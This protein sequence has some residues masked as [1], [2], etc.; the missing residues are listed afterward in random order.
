MKIRIVHCC[1]KSVS[2][3]S[4]QFTDLISQCAWIKPRHSTVSPFT[5]GSSSC[6]VLP[7]PLHL[8]QSNGRLRCFRPSN[9][10]IPAG[11]VGICMR[12]LAATCWPSGAW[13]S[14]PLRSPASLMSGTS[15][16]GI[17]SI[18]SASEEAI[19]L[20][21]KFVTMQSQRSNG[22]RLRPQIEKK[23]LLQK[24][25]HQDSCVAWAAS[26]V[27]L[28]GGEICYNHICNF[29]CRH[30]NQYCIAYAHTVL[31]TKNISLC[32]F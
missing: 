20:N 23:S 25:I 14:S 19:P 5:N 31:K 12:E 3:F 22:R 13:S 30:W 18:G 8:R 16:G 11:V 27:S 28:S 15:D 4:P 9:V 32:L 7:Q 21:I 29:T 6:V 26:S 10:R 24:N 17:A 2:Q 1:T